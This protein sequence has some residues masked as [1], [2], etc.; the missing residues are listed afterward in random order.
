MDRLILTEELTIQDVPSIRP[1]DSGAVYEFAHSFD[2][3]AYSGGLSHLAP[4]AKNVHGFYK[5]HGALPDLSLDDLRAMLFYEIRLY[6]HDDMGYGMNRKVVEYFQVL[7]EAIRQK[8][9]VDSAPNIAQ[10]PSV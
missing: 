6:R 3:Y 9:S 8:L 7:L 1:F 4:I 5:K 2:G 10:K